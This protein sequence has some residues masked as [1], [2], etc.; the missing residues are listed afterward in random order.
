MITPGSQSGEVRCLVSNV[1]LARKSNSHILKRPFINIII[2]STDCCLFCVIF[3]MA[4]MDLC[5]FAI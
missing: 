1:N 2:G 3:K 4:L 5:C